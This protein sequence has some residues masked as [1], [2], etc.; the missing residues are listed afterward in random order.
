MK[1]KQTTL[2][3]RPQYA[4]LEIRLQYAIN[5]AK[6]VHGDKYDYSR[7]HEDFKTQQSKVWIGCKIH[8]WYKQLIITNIGGGNC[9]KCTNTNQP[10]EHRL[11]S[12]INRAKIKHNNKYDYSRVHENFKNQHSE[13]LIGCPVH[14]WVKQLFYNHING[15]DCKHCANVK[16]PLNMRIESSINKAKETHNNKY[17]YSRVHEDFKNQQ[18]KVWIGCPEH[19]FFKQNMNNH[20][21]GKGCSVCKYSHMERVMTNHLIKRGMNFEPQKTF[22]GLVGCG[23]GLLMFDFYLPDHNVAIECD[24]IQHFKWVE[25][26]MPKK[27]YE[28]LLIHDK[29]KNDYCK[30]NGIRLIRLT[31]KDFRDS[32]IR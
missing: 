17:D 1:K 18:S 12:A 9:P 24:G 4:T 30:N 22:D 19:G 27:N 20:I 3:S 25:W 13:V 14:G 11:N 31:V 28:R 23:G 5:R 7:V 15:K 32:S 10:L 2:E 21:N 16:Q 29:R 8:G 26:F 6:E